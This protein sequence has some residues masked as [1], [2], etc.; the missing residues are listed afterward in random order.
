MLIIADYRMPPGA[1]ARLALYGELIEF[2]AKGLVYDAICGHPDIFIC[3][4]PG[5]LVVAPNLPGEMPGILANYNIPFTSGDIRVGG[6]YPETAHYNAV[7]T[8][9]VFI[10]NLKLT[11]KAVLSAAAGRKTIGCKQGYTRCNVLPL[12][13]ER[14]ITSDKP[15]HRLL[16]DNRL[17]SLYVSPEDIILPGVNHGFFGGACGVWNNTVFI[18]GSLKNFTEGTRVREFIENGHYSLIELYD[19]PLI[20][21][22]GLFFLD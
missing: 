9:E 8:N 22:G 15:I 12:G 21:C 2:S 7:S 4:T 3:Q 10:H 6:N 1:K 20:D 5:T 14:F 17:E 11:D 18:C 19:G 13:S 16:L